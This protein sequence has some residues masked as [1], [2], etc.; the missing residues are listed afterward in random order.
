MNEGEVLHQIEKAAIDYVTILPCDRLKHLIPLL[1]EKICSVDLTREEVGIGLCAGVALAGGRPAMLIQSTGAATLLNALFSLTIYY[2]LPLPL[3]ISWRGHYREGIEAQ[4]PLGKRLPDLFSAAGIETVTVEE[5]EEI[6]R[7]GEGI[8]TAFATSMPVAILLSPKIFDPVSAD[9][10]PLSMENV[11]PLRSALQTD[12][13]Y[14]GDKTCG[15]MTRF[16]ALR[17][18]AP[19]LADTAVVVNIGVPSKEYHAIADNASVFYMLGSLG[20]ASAI[21]LGIACFTDKKVAVIDGDGSLLMTPNIFHHIAKYDRD[22]LTVIAIDNGAYG[23][24]GNQKTATATSG[25]DLEL[26]ANAYGIRETAWA[27]T[28]GDIEALFSSDNLPRFIHVVTSAGNAKV[29]NVALGG[30][31]IKRRFMEWL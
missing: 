2:R 14:H 27:G 5:P 11:Q 7:I 4:I 25:I 31:A 22:N 9:P 20:L 21:G 6:H 26:L 19:Y 24:T 30:E 23:S 17:S 10:V 15:A 1:Q 12:L 3:L 13:R 29:G 16:D 18:L 8:D 28:P